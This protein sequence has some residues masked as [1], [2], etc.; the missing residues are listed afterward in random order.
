MQISKTR[1]IIGWALSAIPLSALVFASFG[2]LTGNP[3][4]VESLAKI[5]I[6]AQLLGAVLLAC[7]ILYAIPK[8]TNIG[9]FLLC[10]Y[11]GGVIVAELGRGDMPTVG[12]GLAV[13]L[14]VGTM[15]RKPELSGLG[16]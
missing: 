10:S 5:N 1:K 8:T 3:E 16:I 6:N 13:L 14:Y 15:L 4:L 9:F 2:K 7:I 12:I 11:L